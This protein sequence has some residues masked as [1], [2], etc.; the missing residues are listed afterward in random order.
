MSVILPP[1]VGR[2]VLVTGG[3]RRIGREICLRLA[4]E[5]FSIAV[6]YQTSE[7]EARSLVEEIE[8]IGQKAISIQSDLS[9]PGS[10]Q[11]L[12]SRCLDSIG[13]ISGLVNNAS[14]FLHDDIETVDEASWDSHMAVN[15][16]AQTMLIRI[17]SEQFFQIRNSKP[18]QVSVVNVLDQKV[19][20]PNPDHLSY[21]ASRFAMLGMTEALARALAPRIRVNAV[22]P[23]HTLPSPE[24]SESG[25]RK[26]QSQSPLGYGPDA[27]DIADSVSF[28]MNARAITGQILFVDSGERFLGRQRDVLFETEE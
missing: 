16:R 19:A 21:T 7:S 17:F 10:A 6:H 25:F 12:I 23:G 14:L 2:T 8:S 26:A 28:L 5:G 24:Q 27:S 22:A 3:A 20:S 13:P 11:V 18:A 4:K 15:A 1:Y 9:V